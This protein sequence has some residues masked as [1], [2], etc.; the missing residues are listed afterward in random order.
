[1]GRTPRNRIYRMDRIRMKSFIS[2]WESQLTT[3]HT[4]K[5]KRQGT[6]EQGIGEN[7]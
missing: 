3:N 5:D 4:K 1:M 6:R 2:V 7:H